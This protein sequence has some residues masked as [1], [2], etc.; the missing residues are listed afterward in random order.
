MTFMFLLGTQQR[1]VSVNTDFNQT[2]QKPQMS[3]KN[4]MT[5]KVCSEMNESITMLCSKCEKQVEVPP[6]KQILKIMS[7][8]PP[9][10]LTNLFSPPCSPRKYI[11][12]RNAFFFNRKVLIFSY[13]CRINT[14]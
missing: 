7:T 3:N 11:I 1:D 6:L 4:T 12:K 5:D 2:P 14:I 8:P 13:V 10:S 9:P